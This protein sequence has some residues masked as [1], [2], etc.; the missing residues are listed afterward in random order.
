MLICPKCK[1]EYQNGVEICSDCKCELI[2]LPKIVK[3]GTSHKRWLTIIP[4]IIG[5]LLVLFSPMLS[6][7]FTSSYFLPNGSGQ[8][9][10]EQFTWMLNAYHYSFLLVG[11][12]LWLACILYWFKN[13]RSS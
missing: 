4:F 8:Y 9:I 11:G 3:N 13:Y 6:F 2:E 7:Y 5:I 12:I 10:N 1:S